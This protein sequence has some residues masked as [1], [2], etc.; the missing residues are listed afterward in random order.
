[1]D[2]TYELIIKYLVHNNNTFSNKKGST[3]YA[4]MFP[5]EFKSLLKDN[6]Y[7]LGVSILD[8]NNNNISFWSS[9]LT[10]LNPSFSNTIDKDEIT[11]IGEFKNS[12]LT[13]KKKVD[14]II[15]RESI[16]K[17][18]NEFVLQTIVDIL[19][20][21][22]IIFDFKTV[23]VFLLYHKK[24]MNP[25][26]TTFLFAKYENLWEPIL[27]NDKTEIVRTFDYDSIKDILDLST[28]KYFSSN[29]DIVVSNIDKI[30]KAEKNKLSKKQSDTTIFIKCENELE[31]TN[32][33]EENVKE[34]FNKN[35]LNRMK[36]VE[37]IE[38][39]N[40]LKLKLPEKQLKANLVDV[41]IAS[42]K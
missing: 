15:F 31:P 41:I 28:K 13:S 32:N 25:F 27:L 20:I 38:L 12:I 4:D 3:I 10:L 23:D 34:M 33:K 42:Y 39:I 16:N 30:I 24:E 8:A 7:R 2:I 6:F 14:P 11:M 35:K 21:N 18:P 37:L 19:D 9:F 17:E 29:K 22:I 5:E 1:M 26:K 36:N 40:E